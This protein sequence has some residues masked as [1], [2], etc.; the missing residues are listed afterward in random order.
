M[1]SPDHLA[2]PDRRDFLRKTGVGAAVAGGAW[3][4]PQIFSSPA[5]AAP[6]TWYLEIDASDCSVVASTTNS[7]FGCDPTG[8]LSGQTPPV[9]GV[10]LNWTLT[11]NAGAGDCTDGFVLDI[12]DLGTII[13]FAEADVFCT[14]VSGGNNN[15]C[16]SGTIDG[17]MTQVDFGSLASDPQDCIY[18][19]FRIIIVQGS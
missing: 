15:Q 14:N 1:S 11:E 19:T 13:T 9:N 18:T 17:P 2:R 6:I 16:R 5:G 7:G 8:W 12:S 10:D 3:V 4:V